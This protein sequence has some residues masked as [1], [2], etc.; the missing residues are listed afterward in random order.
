MRSVPSDRAGETPAGV[1]SKQPGPGV[2]AVMRSSAATTGPRHHQRRRG[3]DEAVL[4]KVQTLIGDP[5][6]GGDA[7]ITTVAPAATAVVLAPSQRPG[8]R[9][10]TAVALRPGR[11]CSDQVLDDRDHGCGVGMLS[12]R[13]PAPP[14]RTAVPRGTEQ[15]SLCLDG[16]LAEPPMTPTSTI[17]ADDYEQRHRTQRLPLHRCQ[18]IFGCTHEI[19]IRP[20]RPAECAPG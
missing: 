8:R 13:R 19:R 9:P 3:D 6:C 11:S 4:V 7:R 17:P 18:N 15:L 1:Q 12:R 2:T 16:L 5:I 14:T 10:T 20:M